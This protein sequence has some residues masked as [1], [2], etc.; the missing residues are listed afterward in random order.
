MSE[1]T[2]KVATVLIDLM[3]LAIIVIAMKLLEGAGWMGLVVAAAIAFV[4]YFVITYLSEKGWIDEFTDLVFGVFA[5]SV[6]AISVVLWFN[7]PVW[8]K[9]VAL[10]GLAIILCF[11]IYAVYDVWSFK[12]IVTTAT[13]RREDFRFF[14]RL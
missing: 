6:I 11:N 9:L 14:R 10:A 8:W 1:T 13:D 12:K 7:A 5:I 4:W 2:K 3:F